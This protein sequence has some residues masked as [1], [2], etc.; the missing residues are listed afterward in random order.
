MQRSIV[1]TTL[2]PELIEWSPAWKSYNTVINDRRAVDEGSGFPTVSILT[3][4][5]NRLA[6]L[7]GSM[8]RA[9]EGCCSLF[10]LIDKAGV[11]KAAGLKQRRRHQQQSRTPQPVIPTSNLFYCQRADT[12]RAEWE[13][14]DCVPA[15]PV[16]Y[17]LD[18]LRLQFCS[19][20]DRMCQSVRAAGSERLTQASKACKVQ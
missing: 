10:C 11:V 13:R 20:H 19:R 18:F 4:N 14:K 1:A 15:K 8:S 3:D 2:L 6:G 9:R 5:N 17:Y 12:K 16:S 7:A